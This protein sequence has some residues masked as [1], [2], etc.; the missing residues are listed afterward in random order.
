MAI[1]NYPVPM[2]PDIMQ[3]PDL[4]YQIRGN[5]LKLTVRE[6][7]PLQVV[8]QPC[9]PALPGQWSGL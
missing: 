6:E 1:R 7:N 2:R 9:C 3:K 4:T 5:E 8:N